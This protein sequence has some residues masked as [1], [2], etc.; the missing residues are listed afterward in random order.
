MDHKYRLELFAF[1][2]HTGIAKH[3]ERMAAKGWL[4]EEM[5]AYY[6]TYRRIEPQNIKFAVTYYPE[7]SIL[8]GLS[9]QELLLQDYC[10]AAGWKLVTRWSQ[11]QVYCTDALDPVPLETDA[12]LQVANINETAWRSHLRGHWIGFGAMLFLGLF[13]MMLTTE[14]IVPL[15]V[16]ALLLAAMIWC[17]VELAA[18]YIWYE[19]AERM[20]REEGVLLPT[21]SRR[22]LQGLILAAFL[23]VDLYS[24]VTDPTSSY[25]TITLMAVGVIAGFGLC[26][27]ILKRLRVP[28]E[29][30]GQLAL[31]ISMVLLIVLRRL[32]S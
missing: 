4:L 30:A 19:K 10:E 29:R 32:V 3:L 12:A 28:D 17:V 20:A 23:A 7:S 16:W 25:H 15:G 13:V 27:Y 18:Y 1:Y 8:R 21:K 9:E 22:V 5:G 11:M 31:L 2:D 24:F 6:W 26:R 14:G